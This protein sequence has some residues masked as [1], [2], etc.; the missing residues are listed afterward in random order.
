MVWT[1][2]N[3]TFAT[4]CSQIK[5][6]NIE[7]THEPNVSNQAMSRYIEDILLE[8]PQKPIIL[9]RKPNSKTQYIA[10]NSDRPLTCIKIFLDNC[11]ITE[12][13]ARGDLNDKRHS[14]LDEETLRML[15]NSVQY[16]LA[17]I[18]SSRE[19]LELLRKRTINFSD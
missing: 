14:L 15:E 3:W 7:F 2:L 1:N 4:L 11:P 12:L 8:I 13:V 6:G 17:V 9:A 16:T 10:I 18:E 5:R 19:Y